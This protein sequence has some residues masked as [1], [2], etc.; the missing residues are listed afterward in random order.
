MSKLTVPDSL[1]TNSRLLDRQKR[2][3]E[4]GTCTAAPLEHA[5]NSQLM[6]GAANRK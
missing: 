6:N 1:V 2:R 4:N 3:H 5:V